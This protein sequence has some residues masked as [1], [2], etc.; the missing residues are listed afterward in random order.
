MDTKHSPGSDGRQNGIGAPS[1]EQIHR[2]LREETGLFR[3]LSE[4]HL[5]ALATEARVT[6]HEPN[7][8]VV[9]FGEDADFLGVLLEGEL[10]ASVVGD[11]GLRH[12][13]GRFR[14]G[15]TF[16]EM[17]LMTGDK[18]SED[19]I[20]ETRCGVVRI[21]AALFQSVIM[22][23]PRAVRHL[24][25]TIAVRFR[26][27]MAEPEKAAAAFRQSDDPYGLRLKGGRPEKM[28]VINCGSSSVKYA[29]F[30]TENEANT[31]RG[32]V[33]RIGMVGTRLVQRGPKGE[34]SRELPE[35]GHAEALRAVLEA[36]SAEGAGVIR[37][38]SEISAV[39]HRVVHGGE[40][41]S[42]AV[43]VDEGVLGQIE[44]LSPLAPLH[45]PVNAAGI[46]EARRVFPSAPHVA[47]FDTAFHHTLASFAYLYGLPYALYEERGVRRYGFHGTSHGYAC[48]R[49]AQ[50]LGRRV[51][52]LEIVSCHLGNG[53][54][55]C[56]VDHGRSVDTTM[57]FSPCEG[58]IMGTRC[59][60]LDP[61]V[62]A[63]LE[64]EEGMTC[65]RI[66]AMLNRESGLLGLSGV[67]SDMREVERAAE[68]GA[69]R[70]LIALKAFC[71]R[72][73][74]YI[75]A[76]LAAMGGMDALVFTG[77]IGQGSAGVRSL[78][79]QGLRCM[80]IHLDE[81]CNREADG[82]AGVCRISTD[83][84]PVAVLIVPADEERMIARETLRALGRSYLTRVLEAQRLEPIPVEVSA[85]HIHLSQ[86]H[87]EA[88]FGPG[89][90]LT[91]HSDLSQPGQF[92]C[93][94][95]VTIVGPKDRIER[96]RVLGPARRAT[97]VEISMTEQFKLGIH[98]PI[99]ESG[100]L[101][102]TP[103]CTLEGPAGSVAL[104]Q[105]V[106]CALRHVHMTPEDALRYGVKDKSTVRVRIHGD[107]ELIFGD[108][109]V[110]VDPNFKLAMHIDTD[111]AN[112]AGVK[113]GMLGYLEGMQ[114]Q[115]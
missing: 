31:A 59:G 39:G 50:H 42:E 111:E 114:S 14:R 79:L 15:D 103:G 23:E 115:D 81:R 90:R 21:P 5:A 104:D 85:H 58:L 107:R 105:G 97:Q 57:G 25:K 17:A 52:D 70:A 47:V 78:A 10:S 71:Y 43:V 54:S 13:I 89:H 74:K 82:F 48:L 101:Q 45:N 28:L 94:E 108:V 86:A 84:S 3:H 91:R 12:E 68:E 93:R 36:L 51:N 18:T 87:V 6:T 24:S 26:E 11:G 20:A 56:A 76:Y 16:G 55:L 77:G 75:G 41:F 95:Q 64:R 46:R 65:A 88:L 30:D 53:A 9:E 34:T 66:D 112:G 102:G 109:R 49:A 99:R 83:D 92:A 38:A 62:V 96:V 80:G 110:R 69:P 72:V 98:P 100:D 4:E 67:S 37:E 2:F 8:A 106:I 27:M 35:G 60:D 63:Y 61:G 32:Q 7:E 22:A 33:E 29:F 1:P 40:L 73:R 19:L 44:A 113:T